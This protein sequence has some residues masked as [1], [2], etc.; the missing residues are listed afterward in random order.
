MEKFEFVDKEER[1]KVLELL[2]DQQRTGS[3]NMVRKGPG[4][5]ELVGQLKEELLEKETEGSLP[6][7]EFDFHALKPKID[8]VPPKKRQRAPRPKP[9]IDTRDGA[10]A[11]AVKDVIVF[12]RY[13]SY[14]QK[15]C[16]VLIAGALAGM[17]CDYF[18]LC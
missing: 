14:V 4:A 12:V 13:H 6:A 18:I 15:L 16:T 11:A 10:A 2:E 3:T 17:L 8:D 1:E 7:I 5:A 9:P